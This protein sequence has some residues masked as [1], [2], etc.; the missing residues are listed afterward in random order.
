MKFEWLHPLC[1]F[2][3]RYSI[4]SRNRSKIWTNCDQPNTNKTTRRSNDL[5]CK[6]K[7]PIWPTTKVLSCWAAKANLRPTKSF[8]DRSSTGRS[9]DFRSNT[10]RTPIKRVTCHLL[11]LSNLIG[12]RKEPWSTLNVRHMLETS[13]LSVRNEKAICDSNCWSTNRLLFDF[14]IY[15]I[16][17]TCS[18]TISILGRFLFFFVCSRSSS[19]SFF[20]FIRTF[21]LA[22]IASFF[23][24]FVWLPLD[25]HNLALLFFCSFSS[26]PSLR[27]HANHHHAT[28]VSARLYIRKHFSYLPLH[29]TYTN[30]NLTHTHTHAFTHYIAIHFEIWPSSILPGHLNLLV[31]VRLCMCSRM[32]CSMYVVN[33]FTFRIAPV[34]LLLDCLLYNSILSFWLDSKNCFP[35][36]VSA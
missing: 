27:S 29:K 28:C 6:W 5:S 3:I 34:E 15:F 4:G 20:L 19:A 24:N 23:R 14:H 11:C 10:S 8:S 35:L 17:P 9:K 16:V 31:L 18:I 21:F 25:Y 1:L 12:R 36:T 30:S 33:P 32:L 13:P 7:D 22:F 26:S 2:Q